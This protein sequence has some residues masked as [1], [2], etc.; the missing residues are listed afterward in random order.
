MKK[1]GIPNENEKH[2]MAAVCRRHLCLVLAL[3]S[4]I[5][6]L[7]LAWHTRDDEPKLHG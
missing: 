1:W 3:G 4:R 7:D 5:G 2:I 6:Y